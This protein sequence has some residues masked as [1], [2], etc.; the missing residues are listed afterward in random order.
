MKQGLSMDESVSYLC[1][2]ATEGRFNKEDLLRTDTILPAGFLKE[3]YATP[4][5]LRFRTVAHDL[6]HHDIHPPLYFWALHV[7]QWWQGFG[8][9]NGA[10]LNFALTLCM[11]LVLYAFARQ[12]FASTRLAWAVCAIWI[13]SPAVV[14]IDLEARHYQLLG[15]L[16]LCHAFLLLKLLNDPRS[17]LLNILFAVVNTAG[18]LT[19][20]YF[21]FLMVPGALL[22]FL[23]HG[24]S[25]PAIWLSFLASCSLFVAL[26][27]EVLD[28]P[29]LYLSKRVG[30]SGP[31]NVADR[32]R[33]FFYY[34]LEFFSHW[35]ILR[36][37]IFLLVMGVLI[38]HRRAIISRT[39]DILGTPITG[40]GLVLILLI[41]WSGFTL[42]VYLA[43]I[44]PRFAAGEQ[45]LSYLWPLLAMLLVYFA[46]IVIPR[47]WRQLPALAFLVQLAIACGFAVQNSR[48]VEEFIPQEHY[49][50]INGSDLLIL[51]LRDRAELPRAAIGLRPD[52]EVLIPLKHRPTP[53]IVAV[54]PALLLHADDTLAARIWMRYFPQIDQRPVSGGNKHLVLF[55]SQ[56]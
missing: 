52:L 49:A 23:R 28:F 44:S 45:Y 26:F 6:V 9:R 1:A 29:G 17:L 40:P 24:F 2:S 5:E 18:L 35:R 34:G 10:W 38:V 7:I 14:H 20:Y 47:K 21:G 41:A 54:R 8:I 53:D 46:L 3:Y 50:S 19:H 31:L 48:Y 43:G 15:L 22:L 33:T 27:P 25:V 56:P 39:R 13:L 4:A 55:T 51:G 42:A 37:G 36:Y 16:S 11:L 30:Q 32:A 12:A